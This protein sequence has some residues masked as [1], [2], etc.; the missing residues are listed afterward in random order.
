MRHARQG[1]GLVLLGAALTLTG[2]PARAQIQAEQ[3]Q[4]RFQQRTTGTNIDESI[5]KLASDDPDERV[6][7]VKGLAE[8]NDEKALEYLIQAVGDSDM[9]VKAKAIE[10]LGRMRATEATT[11]LVQ[12]LFLRSTEEKLRQR[13]L[14]AL[15][16]IADPAA[17]PAILDLLNQDLDKATLGTAIF[18]LG[19]IGAPQSIPRLKEI[20]ADHSDEHLRR[21]ATEALAK[22]ERHQESVQREVA[23][24]VDTFLKPPEQQ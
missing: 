20:A 12:Q 1:A 24:P 14:A 23:A 10:M 6:E 11:V 8:S 13:I 17:A 4:Q 9:R 15:G 21:L 3:A 22:V 2:A 5:R 16:E 19:D 18:A 7:G